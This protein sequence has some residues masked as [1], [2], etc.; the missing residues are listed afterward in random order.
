MTYRT[1]STEPDYRRQ[2][3]TDYC[4]EMCQRDLDP[5]SPTTR[6]I[7]NE[8]DQIGQLIHP[9]DLEIAWTEIR[10]QRASHLYD[11]CVVFSRIGPECAKKVGK[12]WTMSSEDVTKSLI[13]A[14]RN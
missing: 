10:Q 14:H 7:A 6:W 4:C 12:A 3:K 8:L 5:A 1:L 2:A 11:R 9:E 13:W